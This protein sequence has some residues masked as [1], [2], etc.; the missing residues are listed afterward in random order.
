M[1][2]L[3]AFDTRSEVAKGETKTRIEYLASSF[4]YKKHLFFT[5]K[6]TVTALDY[7]SSIK[8][9]ENNNYYF[10]DSIENNNNDNISYY[11]KN[12][13]DNNNCSNN[14]SNNNKKEI[15][16]EENEGG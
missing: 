2:D 9:N 11:D 3:V 4:S 7:D 6:K 15:D 8:N 13:N 12:K 14:S 16:G 1:G 10:G 5:T